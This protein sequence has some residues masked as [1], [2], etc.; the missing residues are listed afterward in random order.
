M[1]K[2]AYATRIY[3]CYASIH[4]WISHSK[5][6]LLD[7]HAEYEAHTHTQLQLHLEVE[8]FVVWVY[9]YLWGSRRE[10]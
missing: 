7:R 9:Y 10:G 3:W 6:A 5:D 2:N 4:V 8:A 1:S